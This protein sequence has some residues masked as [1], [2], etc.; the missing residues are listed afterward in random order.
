M[1]LLTRAWVSS[2][3]RKPGSYSH[4]PQSVLLL[5]GPPNKPAPDRGQHL[6]QRMSRAFSFSL[7]SFCICSRSLSP[8]LISA[9]ARDDLRKVR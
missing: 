1:L 2:R 6:L 9:H 5:L 4:C 3:V 8:A 7:M